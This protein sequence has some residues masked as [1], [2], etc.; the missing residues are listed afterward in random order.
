LVSLSYDRFGRNIVEYLTWLE[1]LNKRGV[2]IY[3]ES[4]KTRYDIN[5]VDFLQGILTAQKES[6]LL[7]TRI[8]RSIEYRKKRG[9]ECIGSVPYGKT[10]AREPSGRLVVVDD[11]KALGVIK[12]IM[13][14]RRPCECI[15]DEL[16]ARGLFKKGRKWTTEMVRKYKL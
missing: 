15:A 12:M 14:S 7:S 4:T 6:D 1:D 5:K 8:K 13:S 3:I 2:V 9:D 16:N 11:E 10:F